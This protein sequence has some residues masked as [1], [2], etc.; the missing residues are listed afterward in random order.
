MGDLLTLSENELLCGDDDAVDD[1]VFLSDDDDDVD[2]E[3]EDATYPLL[4]NSKSGRT[5]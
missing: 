3:D 4:H 2:D 1:H 5:T